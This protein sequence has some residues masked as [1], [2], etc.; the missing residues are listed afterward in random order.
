VQVA[1][2]GLEEVHGRRLGRV[3]L[4]ELVK[5]EDGGERARLFKERK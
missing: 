4:G 3:L 2:G 5:N 1:R